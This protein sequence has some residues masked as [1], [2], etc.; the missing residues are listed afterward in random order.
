MTDCIFCKIIRGDVPSYKVYEDDF[1]YA[2]LDIIPINK[3][4]IL[5]VPK[6]HH[7]NILDTPE[8]L[9]CKIIKVVKNIAPIALKAVGSEGFNL[10]VNNGTIAGQIVSHLHFHIVPRFLYDGHQLFQGGAYEAGEAE[11]IQ[12][13]I[14]ELLNNAN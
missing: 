3:G 13:K 9:L 5:V 12:E 2:F 14:V 11:D 4:H 1:I 10:G 7:E 6:E 8:E